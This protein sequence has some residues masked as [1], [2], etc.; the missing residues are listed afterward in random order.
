MT[1]SLHNDL[2]SPQHIQYDDSGRGL[3]VHASA[4]LPEV[5]PRDTALDAPMV[6]ESFDIALH[7]KYRRQ[8][9]GTTMIPL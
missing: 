6:M 3:H 7:A 1:S 5:V 2:A 4:S 9:T 8:F